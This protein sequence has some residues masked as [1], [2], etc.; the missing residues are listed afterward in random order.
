MAK[1][2][3]ILLML[4]QGIFIAYDIT[5]FQGAGLTLALI[6]LASTGFDI[7]SS[8]MEIPT[9]L[10]FD[11]VS[12]RVTLAVGNVIRLVRFLWLRNRYV[13]H[14]RILHHSYHS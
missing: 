10:F 3:N 6:T 13:E 1:L 2:Y 14:S 7:S 9:S 12:P 11:R 5:Y 4:G 8:I